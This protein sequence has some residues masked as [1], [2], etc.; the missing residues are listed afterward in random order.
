V[1]FAEAAGL[2]LL[3]FGAYWIGYTVGRAQTELNHQT[4]LR[5]TVMAEECLLKLRDLN[6][7]C[8][9]WR[10]LAEKGLQK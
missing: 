8:H 5:A 4:A 3:V 10:E 1:K 7:V 9:V 6:G 2:V